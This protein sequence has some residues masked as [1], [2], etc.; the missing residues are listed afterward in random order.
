MQYSV[1][2]CTEWKGDMTASEPLIASLQVALDAHPDDAPLRVHLAR[3]LAQGDRAHEAL[4][5]V[6]YLLTHNPD[7]KVALDLL[8]EITRKLAGVGTDHMR[9][10]VNEPASTSQPPS[11][12]EL[13]G[14]DAFDWTA[15]EDQ[16]ADLAP[17]LRVGPGHPEPVGA[18]ERPNIR[19]ADVA[20]MEQVKL[21]LEAAFLAPQRNPELRAMYRKSLRGGLL[22]YGPP[23]CGKTF[24]AR[25]L[26]GELGAAFYAISLAD[27]LD[28]YIGQSERNLHAVFETVRRH[29]PCVL[30]LDEVDAIGQKRTQLNHSAMRGTVNQLLAELDDVGG[31]NDGVFTLAAT[32]APWDVDSALRRPGRLDR[33]ILVL[34]P[35]APARHA[36]LQMQLKDRPHERID[37]APLVKATEGWS[38]ADLAH[39]VDSATETA[40]LD[41]ARTGRARPITARD[42]TAALKHIRSST[43]TWLESARNVALFANES[44]D[45]DELIA[46]LKQRRML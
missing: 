31:S 10:S 38:G 12:P 40:L 33:T 14:P 25:A 24:L 36:V 15:A 7:D 23:G 34:P 13:A 2:G 42:I 1:P 22:M 19:L 29:A 16:V 27:V 9:G 45:Y 46:Y 30:F 11:H 44:G 28:M 41:A 32:N 3:L 37:L 20:G 6:T 4:P 26:A 8:A 43:T 39:L 35:D 5:H 21:R 18:I 17:L